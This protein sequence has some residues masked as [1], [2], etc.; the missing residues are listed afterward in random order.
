MGRRVWHAKCD[1]HGYFTVDLEVVWKTV[2]EDLPTLAE[3]I[4]ALRAELHNDP[5]ADP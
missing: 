2:C 4:G 1:A 3:Q 5:G